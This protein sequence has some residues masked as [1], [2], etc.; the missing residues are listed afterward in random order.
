MSDFAGLGRSRFPGRTVRFE[1][2]PGVAGG[3]EERLETLAPGE[4]GPLAPA[5]R[6]APNRAPPRHLAASSR[7][8]HRD[9]RPAAAIR[10]GVRTRGSRSIPA[11]ASH[12]VR[13]RS[14]TAHPGFDPRSTRPDDVRECKASGRGRVER[15]AE[16]E[17]LGG[18]FGIA[19]PDPRD[20]RRRSEAF[21][22]QKLS[23]E[24]ARRAARPTLVPRG[25]R[26]GHV[27]SSPRSAPSSGNGDDRRLPWSVI[28]LPEVVVGEDAVHSGRLG[29]IRRLERTSA[30]GSNEGNRTPSLMPRSR[31]VR[32][33]HQEPDSTRDFRSRSAAWRMWR[34]GSS[35]HEPRD[36]DTELNRELVAHFGPFAVGGDERVTARRALREVALFLDPRDSRSAVPSI[37]GST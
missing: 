19:G 22:R 36:R 6:S 24:D 5:P 29:H 17:V 20:H 9:R 14:A 13:R 8:A 37:I 3:G 11:D 31:E 28:E 1:G 33:G 25:F 21:D 2:D 10:S 15:K 4:N 18:T 27:W 23:D 34:L 30:V 12:S 16:G 35:L 32:P 26:D 7:P